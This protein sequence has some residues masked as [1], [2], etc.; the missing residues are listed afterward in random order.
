MKIKFIIIDCHDS[1]EGGRF[2]TY[3]EAEAEITRRCNSDGILGE[4][5]YKIEK[6]WCSGS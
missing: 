5:E 1:S 4:Q 6:R 3:E 2:D